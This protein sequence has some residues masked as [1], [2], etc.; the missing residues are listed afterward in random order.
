[1]ISE[2]TNF[3]ID[4]MKS[5]Y[6]S[7]E[8]NILKLS[9]LIYEKLNVLIEKLLKIDKPSIFDLPKLLQFLRQ[10]I[11][12]LSAE[13][14]YSQK[15]FEEKKIKYNQS[16][17]EYL[18]KL[19]NKIEMLEHK[20]KE[21]KTKNEKEKSDSSHQ[22]NILNEKILSLENKINVISKENEVLK[23]ENILLNKKNQ[24]DITSL[25]IETGKL[26]VKID[27]INKKLEEQRKFQSESEKEKVDP[28]KQTEKIN[29]QNKEINKKYEEINEKLD[30]FENQMIGKQNRD[31]Y[32]SIIY[33]LLIYKGINFKDIRNSAYNLI[34][35]SV[36]DEDI[37][38]ILKTAYTF[39][40][41]HSCS[42][43][44][45]YNDDI[46]KRLFPTSKFIGKISDDL[47]NRTKEILIKYENEL[48][49][50]EDE[51]NEIEKD[52]KELTSNIKKLNL[53]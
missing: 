53:D 45:G 17:V 47:I 28:K 38:K 3:I 27:S 36:E 50:N 6:N 46:M 35:N 34:N 18:N 7:Q 24:Q 42:E 49:S 26:A 43:I 31:N 2:D 9:G 10:H 21:D 8:E 44:E 33:I 22:I 16:V 11:H 19:K 1:M 5:I 25:K 48:F 23:K 40:D 15:L 20:T 52:I 12:N 41:Y 37:Q 13:I 32:K 51:K 29:E 39:Y 4:I 14:I 30:I